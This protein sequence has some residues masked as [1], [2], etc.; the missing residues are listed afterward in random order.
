E[1]SYQS[2][3]LINKKIDALN[4]FVKYMDKA[5]FK[6]SEIE[7]IDKSVIKQII[8]NH[9]GHHPQAEGLANIL[10]ESLGK[11]DSP[12]VL[13][14]RYTALQI[15]N[16]VLKTRLS[17]SDTVKEI[18]RFIEIFD[19]IDEDKIR[20]TTLKEVEKAKAVYSVGLFGE[21]IFI[22][23]RLLENMLTEYILLLKTAGEVSMKNNQINSKDFDFHKKLDFLYSN[24]L[25]KL[26]DSEHSK[27]MSLKW[28]RNVY[29]HKTNLKTKD[30]K[31][32]VSIGLMGNDLLDTRI[33]KLKERLKN[34]LANKKI[35][36]G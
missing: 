13:A 3:G 2:I 36:R 32:M 20:K 18:H 17:I 35:R 23:G 14:R 16:V 26:S 4:V 30:H 19:V 11:G 1:S 28:D 31:A 8:I 12:S 22:L 10:A 7:K 5:G 33:Q 9:K 27:L 34:E 6:L 15:A 29:G 25:G 24:K 21:S